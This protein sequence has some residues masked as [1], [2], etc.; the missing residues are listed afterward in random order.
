MASDRGAAVVEMAVVT[1][2]LALLV[3]GIADLGRAIFTN[4]AVRDA[5][6]DGAHFASYTP[7]ATAAEIEGRIN[8]VARVDLSGATITLYCSTQD[9]QRQDGTRIRVELE[10][11]VDLITPIVGP[12]LG[13]SITLRPSAEADRFFEACPAGVDTPI[14]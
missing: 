11:E 2:F 4:V 10:H 9:R 8:S 1:I 13:G 3:L 6:Q 12:M 5:V 14:P 7:D